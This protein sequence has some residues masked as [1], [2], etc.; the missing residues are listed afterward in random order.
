MPPRRRPLVAVTLGLWLAVLSAMLLGSATVLALDTVSLGDMRWI[1][2]DPSITSDVM[3]RIAV[4]AGLAVFVTSTLLKSWL[5]P[6]RTPAAAG[7]AAG[8]A[9]RSQAVAPGTVGHAAVVRI[10]AGSALLL[11]AGAGMVAVQASQLFG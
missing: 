4:F 1:G 3:S 10:V 9:A 6:V 11:T 8:P 7:P 5:G 2:T